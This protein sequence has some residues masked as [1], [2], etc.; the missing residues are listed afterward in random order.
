MATRSD[1]HM[2]NN[3]GFGWETHKLGKK[4]NIVYDIRDAPHDTYQ[5]EYGDEQVGV[6]RVC[7][8][9]LARSKSQVRTET[10]KYLFSLFS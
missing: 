8:N 4:L 3:A 7:R 10:G 2:K 1:F 9:R 5:P 6:G